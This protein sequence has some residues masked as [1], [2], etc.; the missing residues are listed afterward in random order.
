MP[1]RTRL[2]GDDGANTIQDGQAAELIYGFDPDGSQREVRAITA[3]RVATGLT[4]PVFV[5]APP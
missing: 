3:T 1:D 2:R 5:A 4:F